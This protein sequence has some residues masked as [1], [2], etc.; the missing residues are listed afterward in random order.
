MSRNENWRRF[1]KS[2]RTWDSPWLPA[3]AG[4]VCGALAAATVAG[5]QASARGLTAFPIGG[6]TAPLWAF[7]LGLLAV[8]LPILLIQHAAGRVVREVRAL[9]N[10][11]PFTGARLL[12][13]DPWEMD[14]VFAERLLALLDEGRER[15]VELGSGHSTLLIA[16]RLEEAGRG[17]VV[18]V[19]HLA[20]YVD[21][22]RAWLREA[23][24]EHRAE[25]VHAPI[26]ERDVEGRRLPWY[27]AAPLE[28][29]LPDGIDLLVV[30][31]PSDRVGRD[32]RWP[33]VPLLAGRL[34]R[35]AAILMDDGDRP[36]ERRAA[37]DWRARLDARIRYLPG[38]RGGW[39]L[40]LP[41]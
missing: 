37:A 30:D 14:A 24:L 26:E 18:S 41:R 12:S 20:E 9:I 33:A 31:G 10:V 16:R 13:P 40:R 17:R 19:D 39:L 32:A 5:I 8:A 27:A 3:A 22:T 25:V 34:A 1:R 7:L 38:G 4:L 36:A 21:R 23:G 15:V 2:N 29:A 35:D 11:R 6:W 28:A